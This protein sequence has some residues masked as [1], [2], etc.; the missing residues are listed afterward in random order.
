VKYLFFTALFCASLIAQD[1]FITIKNRKF[2]SGNKEYNFLGFNAYYLQSEAASKG[3][4]YI[5]DS[6]FKQAS[7]YGIKVIRTWAFNEGDIG[8]GSGVIMNAPY[9]LDETGLKGL[10]YV[11]LR[12]GQYGIKLILALA[13]N[14]SDLGGIPQYLG[15]EK[16]LLNINKP[17]HSDFFSN[18]SLKQWYKFYMKSLLERENSFTGIKYKNDKTIFA[19]ELINEASNTGEPIEILLDWYNEMSVYFK[20]IDKNHLLTT[21]EEGYDNCPQGYSG[22]DLFYNGADYL[23]N[24]YKGSSFSANA[25]LSRIDYCS[26]HLY[27][28]LAGFSLPAGKTWITDH[29]AIADIYLKPLLCGELG[30]KTDKYNGYKF[31]FD[32]LRKTGIKNCILWQYLHPDVVNDDGFGFNEKNDEALME[33]F[34]NYALSIETDTVSVPQTYDDVVLFQNFPNPFNPVTTIRYILNEEGYVS[35]VLTNVLGMKVGVIDEGYKKAGSYEKILSFQN[36]RLASGV[37]FYTLIFKDK[38]FTKKIT[39]QK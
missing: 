28:A 14:Y 32:E 37:Y 38:H 16:K 27:P 33:L 9:V 26:V 20:S 36:S 39:L 7:N 3:R 5:I 30:V 34:K 24:G 35:L 10:D 17:E 11:A 18:D 8:P 12:A 2:Y 15:W 31:Y 29:A 1:N 13:N 4:Q 22:A 21:G 19:F 23:F 6:V 25:G